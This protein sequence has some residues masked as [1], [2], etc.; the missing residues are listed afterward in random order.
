LEILK[1]KNPDQAMQIEMQLQQMMG[2]PQEAAA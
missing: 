2:Q 1:K